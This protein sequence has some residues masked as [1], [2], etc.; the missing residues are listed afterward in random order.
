MFSRMK[1]RKNE[2]SSKIS[3]E[4]LENLLRAAI[5]AIKPG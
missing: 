4:H 2:I 5:S 1:H 3:D